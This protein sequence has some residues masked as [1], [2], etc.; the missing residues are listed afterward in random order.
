MLKE[1]GHN[2]WT[3]DGSEVVAMMGF[4]YPTRM[5]VIRLSDKDLFVWSPISLTESLRVEVDALGE[6]RYLVD[7][8]PLKWSSLKY[9]F[10]VEDRIDG[11]EE[12]YS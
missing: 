3:A 12:A 10:A 7:L 4:H 9:G 2:I 5:A 8:P 1:F 11:K 6:V